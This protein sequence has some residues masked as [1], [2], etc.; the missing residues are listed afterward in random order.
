MSLTPPE[1]VFTPLP[2]EIIEAF[3]AMG[4]EHKP[5]TRNT[6]PKFDWNMPDG[7]TVSVIFTDRDR[8]LLSPSARAIHIHVNNDLVASM[9]DWQHAVLVTAAYLQGED[10]GH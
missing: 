8:Q 2:D 5:E 3:T 1:F 10:D 7:G 4:G 9:N 6:W